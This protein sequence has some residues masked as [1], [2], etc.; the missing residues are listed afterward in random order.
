MEMPPL[1]QFCGEEADKFSLF[2]TH[3]LPFLPTLPTDEGAGITRR[4]SYPDNN[5]LPIP[6]PSH[7]VNRLR[8][9]IN[10]AFGVIGINRARHRGEFIRTDL[11]RIT[12]ITFSPHQR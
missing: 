1:P 7:L 3:P 4:G 9:V 2:L 11:T 8:R 12:Q 6:L 10:N 5:P